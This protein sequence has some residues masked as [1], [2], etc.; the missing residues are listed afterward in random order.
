MEFVLTEMAVFAGFGLLVLGVSDL[1]VDL[2]WF[3]ARRAAAAPVTASRPGRL[4]IFVP[5]W[6]EAAVIGAMLAHAR[7]AFGD[8]DYRLYVGC[9]PNDPATIAAV[10]GAA[11]PRLRLVVGPAPGPTSKAD[12]L[13]RLWERLL[14]DEAAEGVRVKAIVLHDA[15][16]VVHSAEL[17]LFD[18]LSERFD[19]VQVPVVPLIDPK[20]RLIAG[21]YCDEFAEAHGKELVVRAAL[22]AAL[23]SAGVGCAIARDALAALAAAQDAPF[24]AGSLTEDYELGIR[25]GMI[26][27]RAV[28][29][30][31]PAGPGR[32]LV[33]T[34][35]YFPATLGAAVAQKARW[36]GGIALA[37]WDRLGWSG[38]LAERW[39]RLRDRQPILA[40]FVLGAAYLSLFMWAALA[41]GG[42]TVPAFPPVFIAFAAVNSLLLLW[43]LAM[44]FG[45]VAHAYGWREGLWSLPR[46]AVSNLIL[47]LAAGR[48]LR[49][50]VNRRGSA[51]RAWDKTAHAFP[52][53]LPAE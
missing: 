1:A 14:E 22:G 11:W 8:A 43:R 41:L 29:A 32:A 13:N 16:D 21:H 47:I 33:T 39:M 36:V 48:A 19:L 4:A 20:S 50:Y 9:Y 52:C 30:R 38:G 15:E 12:C 7:A 49:R 18:A 53:R 37:G 27:R 25:L 34:R 44:R 24:D 17:G 3:F 40:A 6:D 31:I 28:L 45:F 23:P 42:Q 35:A 2:A 46:A 10:R 5:A 26:G 51:A